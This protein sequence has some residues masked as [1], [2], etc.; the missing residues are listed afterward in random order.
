MLLRRVS[1]FEGRTTTTTAAAAAAAAA[2][3]TTTRTEAT[4]HAAVP[5][6]VQS[7]SEQ[8]KIELVP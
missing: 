4:K 5:E 6:P 1:D 8:D 3:R 7:N 2:I